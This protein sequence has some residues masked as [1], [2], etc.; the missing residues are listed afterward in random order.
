MSHSGDDRLPTVESLRQRDTDYHVGFRKREFS[1][2]VDE[3]VS[4][5]E[6]CY[7]G[8]WSFLPECRLEGPDAKELL[9]D[10]SVNSFENFEIGQAKHVIQCN[11]NG[12]IVAEGLLMRLD[13]ETYSASANPA[14]WT[15]YNLEKGEYDA[16]WR[17]VDTFN[18]QVQGPTS[19]KVLEELVGDELRDVEFIH[20]TDVEIG[21]RGVTAIR[22]GMAGEAGFELQ[23][24]AEYADEIWNAVL[25][26]GED[27]DIKQLGARTVMI[28]HLEAC[29]PTRGKDYLPAIYHEGMGEFNEWKLENG[30]GYTGIVGIAG[31]FEGDDIS[32]YY[33]TPVELGWAQNI[34][35]DHE[36]TGRDALE[37]EVENPRREI[38]TLEW[39]SDDVMDVTGSLYQ[40]ETPYQPMDMPAE[41]QWQMRADKVLKDD[42]LVGIST[43]RGYSYYFR[44]MLS[45]CTIDV[46]CKEPGTEV[47]V[48]WGDPDQRQKEIS[49]TVAPAP[50]KKDN[51]RTDLDEYV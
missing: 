29:F 50:Y 7:I 35:L 48:V 1:G 11:E 34:A 42:D 49:A 24:P 28:N 15:G 6:S 22:M 12:S 46:E 37:D 13:E 18:F 30:G 40:E 26:A 5:K 31:S 19:I 16:D 45:L 9:S 25:D 17:T 44:E 47:T 27:H 43:S 14:F 51:R 10:I 41:Q 38:V 4:W 3:Q 33:R 32:D 39:D 2:W 36:F 20:F 21:G 8:D 23:G